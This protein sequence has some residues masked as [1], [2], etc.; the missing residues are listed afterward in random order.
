[1]IQKIKNNE[2]VGSI[3]EQVNNLDN[4]AIC[5]SG[6]AT[7]LISM[8][9]SHCIVNNFNIL[10]I[11]LSGI[12]T[13]IIFFSIKLLTT[14][15]GIGFRSLDNAVIT[16]SNV[17]VVNSLIFISYLINVY[18]FYDRNK[19]FVLSGLLASISIFGLNYYMRMKRNMT[20]MLPLPR[21][22]EKIKIDVVMLTV[23]GL[24]TAFFLLDL[25]HNTL[26]IILS[27]SLTVYILVSLL[28]YIFLRH[29]LV[30]FKKAVRNKY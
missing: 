21:D 20:N 2:L 16:M 5:F 27:L 26:K 30:I 19:I 22:E 14:T 13:V 10:G 24:L 17:I 7:V 15:S 8:L 23:S 6:Y 9:L 25:N 28:F 1:M 12:F 11:S 4:L 3:L 18:F 29:E